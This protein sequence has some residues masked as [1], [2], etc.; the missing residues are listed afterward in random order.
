MR[1]N[2][3]PCPA[4]PE[5][6][7]EAYVMETLDTADAASFEE[8]CLACARCLAIVEATDEYV[9]AMR[10]AAERLCT[11]SAGSRPDESD[12]R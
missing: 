2:A 1:L 6:V 5:E 3:T 11:D 8:H 7:A 12:A 9:R 10:E 4:N